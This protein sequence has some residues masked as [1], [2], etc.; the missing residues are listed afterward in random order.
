MGEASSLLSGTYQYK[1][2]E[3]KDKV[4]GCGV[5]ESLT[6]NK[7]GSWIDRHWNS[8]MKGAYFRCHIVS[9]SRRGP[10]ALQPG[11]SEDPSTASKSIVEKSQ[12]VKR[13]A[14]ITGILVTLLKVA[15]CSEFAFSWSRPNLILPP[16]FT[17]FVIPAKAHRDTNGT[18][19]YSHAL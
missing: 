12:V 3:H 7:R 19:A 2:K 14:I 1:R 11:R 9:I 6:L 8:K 10:S 13:D 5:R 4:L 17:T 18:T 15:R 16:H